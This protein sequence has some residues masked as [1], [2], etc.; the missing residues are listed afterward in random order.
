MK[1]K[2]CLFG[3]LIP[4]LLL[5][6]AGCSHEEVGGNE[7]APA[8]KIKLTA[9]I[10]NV[11]D[12][13]ATK[14]DISTASGAFS[15]TEGDKIAVHTSIPYWMTATLESG[16]GTAS[17]VFTAEMNDTD[18]DGYAIYP[19]SMAGGSASAPTITLPSSYTIDGSMDT[20]SPLP[21]IAVNSPST[22]LAFKHLGGIFRI[23]LNNVPE[24]TRSIVVTTDKQITGTF[25]VE[26]PGTA[27]PTIST[28]GS[29]SSNTVT[30]NFSSA[31][32][33]DTDGV[34]LNVPIPVGA[35]ST[36]SVEAYN[37]ADGGGTQLSGASN[38]NVRSISRAS[39]RKISMDITSNEYRIGSFV[40]TDA[41]T[42]IG[43]ASNDGNWT[44]LT[45]AAADK[46]ATPV[47]ITAAT[48]TRIDNN[49][50]GV[51]E[52]L[53]TTD[54]GAT[55]IKVRAKAGVAAGESVEMTF[56]MTY[57]DDTKTATVTVTTYDNPVSG[58]AGIGG[59][60]L[61]PGNA[62]KSG[63]TW[64]NGASYL[65]NLQYYNN[66][67]SAGSPST[68]LQAYFNA[69]VSVTSFDDSYGT[70]WRAPKEDE[71]K[72]WIG[73]TSR[74][75]AT[76]TLNGTANQSGKYYTKVKIIGLNGIAAN[77][78]SGD[79]VPNGYTGYSATAGAA[80]LQGLLLF[81]EGAT[82]YYDFANANMAGA[83]FA[84]I[85]K[86]N[87]DELIE[88]GCAFLPCAGLYNSGWYY[89]GTYGYY[90]CSDSTV[91]LGF[92]SSDVNTSTSTD[93][94]SVRLVRDY[95]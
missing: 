60:I 75:G 22:A 76:I 24:T 13:D 38:D 23:T 57:Y 82:I 55:V 77:A 8:D 83:A 73:S 29:A 95:E 50:D 51:V 37:A 26:N 92:G 31:F 16:A 9:T 19:A 4:S 93:Y 2:K 87:I 89:S 43:D 68:S 74:T 56:R 10:E 41:N 61:A 40:I 54:D 5:A 84:E 11:Q 72:K 48:I 27:T 47:A 1:M 80:Y 69:A 90:R 32:A 64:T 94:Y 91:Y 17:G 21:M 59:V 34:V 39:G 70:D 66:Q 58:G 30:F 3:A 35:Y 71:L 88:G 53:V 33:T 46:Q 15:W 79:G 52:D 25:T 12:E 42:R 7:K 67:G 62:I 81:P 36:L 78:S 86:E 49:G 20:F 14:V 28:S 85:S 65:A 18:R 45:Y 44:T 63:T 6:A